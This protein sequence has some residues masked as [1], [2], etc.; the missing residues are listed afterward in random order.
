MMK[1]LMSSF[2]TRASQ[3]AAQESEGGEAPGEEELELSAL[4]PEEQRLARFTSGAV[5]SFSRFF[6]FIL[7]FWNQILTCVSFSSSVAATSTLRALVRYLLKWNS[8]SSSVSCLVVKLVRI[9]FCWPWIPY[10]V[11]LTE[12]ETKLW[13]RFSSIQSLCIELRLA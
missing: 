2:V 6:C 3:T 9:I 1:H 11:T 5:P 8:F 10:S 7:R 12:R 4:S 13:I